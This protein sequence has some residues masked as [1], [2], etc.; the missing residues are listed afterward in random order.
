MPLIASIV[1]YCY[2][3]ITIYVLDISQRITNMSANVYRALLLILTL[4]VQWNRYSQIG[5]VSLFAMSERA[6]ERNVTL[7][8]K[9][10]AIGYHDIVI[11][12]ITAYRR[13]YRRHY[14]L[15]QCCVQTPGFSNMIRLLW[16]THHDL[17]ERL[18]SSK[19]N[20]ESFARRPT[21][22]GDL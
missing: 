10:L 13:H 17:T 18:P 21:L 6:L 15:F 5:L 8:L 9:C 14:S 2:R 11:V 4:L 3:L 12:D 7:V 20:D 19:T 16:F 22:T 1:I